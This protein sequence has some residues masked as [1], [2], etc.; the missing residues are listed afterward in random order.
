M[1]LDAFIKNMQNLV[2]NTLKVISQTKSENRILTLLV[3]PNTAHQ[4]GSLNAH[5]PMQPSKK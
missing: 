4:K 2:Q 5:Y 3:Y 1:T